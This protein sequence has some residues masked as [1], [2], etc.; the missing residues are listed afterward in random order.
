MHSYTILNF[1]IRSQGKHLHLF[2]THR[3]TKQFLA[4]LI[5]HNQNNSF[6]AIVKICNHFLYTQIVIKKCLL[7]FFIQYKKEKMRRRASLKND[8]SETT[9]ERKA[10]FNDLIFRQ[11]LSTKSKP[12]NFSLLFSSWLDT[13]ST[14]TFFLIQIMN[15]N[16]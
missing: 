3:T 15:T 9:K 12:S 7:F 5:N 14:N 11:N 6:K 13:K 8:V 4:T 1:P 16:F 10:K 2:L